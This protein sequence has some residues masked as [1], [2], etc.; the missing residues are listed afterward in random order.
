MIN[1][2]TLNVK[3]DIS[4]FL[5]NQYNISVFARIN[6]G[7][8][9][10]NERRRYSVT[11]SSLTEPIPWMIAGLSL[12]WRHNGRDGV[13][14]HQPHDC[15][16]NQAQINENIKAPRH[17][18]V[19]RWPINFPHKWP[20]ARKMFPFDDVIMVTSAKFLT[21][22]PVTVV[23]H[24]IKFTETSIVIR[25]KVF[26]CVLKRRLFSQPTDSH[27]HQTTGS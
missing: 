7:M 6:L 16:L 23:C 4:L 11:S 19:H 21:S 17:C 15:L 10:T 13:S 9:S 12:L 1:I 24:T 8:G 26:V 22:L 2:K 20:V 14:K 27:M 25:T 5:I 3:C 18:F